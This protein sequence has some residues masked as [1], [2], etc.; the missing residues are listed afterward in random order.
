M[1]LARKLYYMLHN[2]FRTFGF[3]SFGSYSMFFKPLRVIGK[4]N[5]YIG[6]NCW[7]YKNARLETVSKWGA[8]QLHGELHIK[9]GVSFEQGCHI[10][11]ASKLVIEEG[12]TI[13][14]N[15]YISDCGHSHEKPNQDVMKQ[16]LNVKSVYIGKNSFIGYG[17]CVLSGAHIGQ[18]CIIGANAVVKGTIPD[19]SIAVGVP[20]KIIKQYNFTTNQWEKYTE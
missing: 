10:V 4:K 14:A 9:D 18:G 15:V 8:Q 13:S 7:I 17:A 11:A 19:Y 16:E 1:E 3:G 2:G 12:C 20:A 5:I 6:N